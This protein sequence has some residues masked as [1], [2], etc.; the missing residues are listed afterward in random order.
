MLRPIRL[1]YLVLFSLLT[2]F[3]AVVQWSLVPAQNRLPATAYAVLKQGMN[4][5]LET[6]T[7]A[8]MIGALASGLVVLVLA[9]RAASPT[10][11]LQ[12]LALAGLAAMVAS[13]LIINAPIN[14]AIDA[15]NAAQPPADWQALRD[16]WEFG[17]MLRSYVG[18]LSLTAALAAALWER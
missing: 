2:G 14:H 3:M 18:L 15:W 10:R 12:A 1:I 5:I 17:H 6:L 8:L 4:Q 9:W 13:T 11:W 16:R 7:P